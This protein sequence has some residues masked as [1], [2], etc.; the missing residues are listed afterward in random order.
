MAGTAS[1]RRRVFSRA[2]MCSSCEDASLAPSI[3]AQVLLIDDDPGTLVTFGATLRSAGHAVVCAKSA[4]EGL[5]RLARQWIDVTIS[6]LRL[7]DLSGLDV[8]RT[9]RRHRVFTPFVFVTAFP[10]PKD[11]VIAMRMGAR[12]FVTKPL[13]CEHLPRLVDASLV[14]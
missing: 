12:D 6:D 8:L 13:G 5:D 14:G 7:P 11:M 9:I 1:S 10:T 2:F 4:L 3:M